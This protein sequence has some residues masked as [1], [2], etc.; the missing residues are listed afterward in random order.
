MKLCPKQRFPAEAGDT[1]R[2]AVGQSQKDKNWMSYSRSTRPEQTQHH[3]TGGKR[4]LSEEQARLRLNCWEPLASLHT[5]EA[6]PTL[7]HLFIALML[8]KDYHRGIIY[9]RTSAKR[10]APE[11]HTGSLDHQTPCLMILVT[12]YS[13]S[14]KA[15]KRLNQNLF[16]RCLI[17]TLKTKLTVLYAF[18]LHIICIEHYFIFL[19]RTSLTRSNFWFERCEYVNSSSLIRLITRYNRCWGFPYEFQHACV[20]TVPPWW[21]INL[22][23]S[24]VMMQVFPHCSDGMIYS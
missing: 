18:M 6:E 15:L 7:C 19:S 24:D 20:K 1:W 3:C 10:S 13:W 5:Y 11:R 21:C 2:A 14:N 22:T 23:H 9:S 4:T 17:N 8:S 12:S 16:W